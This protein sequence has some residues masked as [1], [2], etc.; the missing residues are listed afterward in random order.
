MPG[1]T[2][3]FNA[4]MAATQALN[5]SRF[6]RYI[7]FT[8]RPSGIAILP[9]ELIRINYSRLG[10]GTGS[11][12]LFRVKSVSIAKDCLVAIT[13]EEHNDSDYHS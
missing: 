7:S 13:A 8:M 9:G 5:F 12:V 3:Y 10:W 2:N 11:E 4:R 6:S 1:I